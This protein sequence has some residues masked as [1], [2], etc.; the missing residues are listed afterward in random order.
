MKQISY[1]GVT[2]VTTDR[3]SAA[4]LDL[5]AKLGTTNSTMSVEVP[6]FREGSDVPSV[7]GLV[8][9]PS[10]ELASM[11][12]DWDGPEPEDSATVA[13][14]TDFTHSLVVAKP[15]ASPPDEEPM[16]TALDEPV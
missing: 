7:V 15:V 11:T 2:F 6:A 12:T 16:M 8:I 14:F 10:S 5:T 13:D 3:V 4:L 9:G 1:S